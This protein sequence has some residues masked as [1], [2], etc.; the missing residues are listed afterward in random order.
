MRNPRAIVA[1]AVPKVIDDAAIQRLA[2]L[3][4]LPLGADLVAFG[5]SVRSAVFIYARDAATPSSNEVHREIEK[6]HSLARRRAYGD[7]STAIEK[8]TSDARR[9]LERRRAALNVRASE[10]LKRHRPDVARRILALRIPNP[11]ELHDP[12][13]REQAATGLKELIEVEVRYD[14]GRNRPSGRH[15]RT[16]RPSLVAPEAGRGEPRR[17]AERSLVMWL[18]VAMLEAVEHVPTTAQH[19]NP[20]PFARLAAE[21]LR[22]VGATG[23]ANAKGLAVQM[24][25]DLQDRRRAKR[26]TGAPV[27]YELLKDDP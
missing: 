20:G 3:A 6:L 1:E 21:V 9:L 25:N 5:Q 14:E 8:M 17:E 24:I 18:Q 23:P 12:D 19:N 7:L 16:R 10:M 15:S 22:L 26:P 4:K 13:R 11:A 2:V 27:T